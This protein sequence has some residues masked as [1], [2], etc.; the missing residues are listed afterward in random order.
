MPGDA[1]ICSRW[2]ADTI[3]VRCRAHGTAVANAYHASSHK[4][5]M[6]GLIASTSSMTRR[7]L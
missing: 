5:Q 3:A 6:S 4:K 2:S 7:G 1:S